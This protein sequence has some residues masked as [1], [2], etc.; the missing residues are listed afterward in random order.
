MQAGAAAAAATS[1][2][3]PSSTPCFQCC[4]C[5]DD[6]VP[7]SAE[8]F[9]P[10]CGATRAGSKS[11]IR[12][13]SDCVRTLSSGDRERC[14]RCPTCRGFL[15]VSEEP[16][17]RR[18][19]AAALGAGGT[20]G[21]CMQIRAIVGGGVCHACRLGNQYPLRYVCAHCEG[22]QRIPHP[23]WRYMATRHA[24]SDETWA[25]QYCGDYRRWRLSSADQARVPQWEVPVSWREDAEA[26]RDELIDSL[27]ERRQRLLLAASPEDASMIDSRIRVLAGARAAGAAAGAARVDGPVT[28]ADRADWPSRLLA[29]FVLCCVIAG[30]MNWI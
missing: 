11:Y 6:A 1:D 2:S 24:V 27:R 10:C 23:L 16:G 21:C 12:F 15:R 9:L 7:C 22:V 20:C 13:C 14:M 18:V 26:A 3:E 8:V 25:C 29:A 28:V 30:W 19:T 17:T 4:I 5:L